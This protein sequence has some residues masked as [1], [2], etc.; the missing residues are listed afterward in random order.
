MSNA[1]TVRPTIVKDAVIVPNSARHSFIIELVPSNGTAEK[2]ELAWREQAKRGR[3]AQFYSI[4]GSVIIGDEEVG[5]SFSLNAVDGEGKFRKIG[6]ESPG[7]NAKGEKVPTLQVS[8]FQGDGCAAFH[9]DNGK[10]VFD[11][12]DILIEEGP[13]AGKA[14]PLFGGVKLLVFKDARK[15]LKIGT[16]RDLTYTTKQVGDTVKTFATCHAD[17]IEVVDAPRV[18]A[19]GDELDFSAIEGASAPKTVTVQAAKAGAASA[20][21]KVSAG[22]L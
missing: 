4:K 18:C 20:L 11:E 16:L 21:A 19:S 14:F 3:K 7:T 10:V 12:Q 2:P 9:L 6:I 22:T 17:C 5:V 8:Q 1:F 15:T 13:D